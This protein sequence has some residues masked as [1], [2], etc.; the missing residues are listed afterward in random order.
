MLENSVLFRKGDVM[1][2]TGEQ[3]K[4]IDQYA[5]KSME[6]PSIVLME[7]AALKVIDKIDLNLRHSFAIFCGTGNNGGDGLAIARGLI[8][9]GKTVSVFIVGNRESMTDEFHINY[10]ILEHMRAEVKWIKTLEDLDYMIQ[11]MQEVNTLID[12][13]FGIGLSREVRGTAAVVIEQINSSRIYTISVDIPSG[14]HATTGKIL[15][16]YV[17]ANEVVCLQYLKSGLVDN[18][19]LHCEISVVE[20][21]IPEQ[22]RKYVMGE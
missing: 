1:V 9:C 19:Y 10:R 11:K 8:N 5:I 21:G 2:V 12:C 7:N 18:Q 6:I 3:M 4:A 15:G 14:I 13:I 20:I 22:A 17:E 16:T